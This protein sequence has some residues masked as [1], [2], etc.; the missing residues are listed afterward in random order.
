VDDGHRPYQTVND[1]AFRAAARG[2]DYPLRHCFILD[3]GATC[4][5]ANDLTRFVGFRD[6]T[7][8]DY[9][10]A[11]NTQVWIKGYGS[12]HIQLSGPEGTRVLR[13]DDVAYC[14]DILCNLVSF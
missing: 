5:I 11:G 14:P 6:P 2:D 10:W 4:H 9:I 13:L 8:G 3:S 12:V 7:P 1:T